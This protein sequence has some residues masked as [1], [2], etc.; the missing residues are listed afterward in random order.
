MLKRKRQEPAGEPAGAP[1]MRA[2]R[3]R[4]PLPRSL[5]ARADHFAHAIPRWL[6]LAAV[7]LASGL[8]ALLFWQYL[9]TSTYFQVHTW[10]VS[11][12]ERLS[13]EDILSLTNPVLRDEPVSLITFNRGHAEQFLEDCPV[14]RAA[15][16]EKVWP[17]QV[18][19]QILERK[20]VAVLIGEQNRFLVDVEGVLLA[21]AGS[22]DLL[23]PELPIITGP[24]DR[25]FAAGEQLES[26]FRD[27]AFAYIGTLS[28]VDG[29]L[30]GTL[31]EV[32]WEPV[33]G[34]TVYLQNGTRLIC[35]HAKP[36]ETLPRAE[37]LAAKIGGLD[38]VD[39]A[40]LRIESHLPWKPFAG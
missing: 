37:A 30:S 24:A 35:G 10:S 8:F 13:K 17:Q 15:R 1:R 34:V 20:P 2:R 23:N 27:A 38:T 40:D 33:A 18:D 36:W 32:H 29:P 16:V 26:D 11:G 25:T 12:N 4:D 3:Q 28:Q 14:V 9:N 5:A 7:T 39:Y 31:S 22:G 19:I 21:K 6:A